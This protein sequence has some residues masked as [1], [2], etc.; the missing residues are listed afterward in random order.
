MLKQVS[1]TH[2]AHVV[3]GVDAAEDMKLRVSLIRIVDSM[4]IGDRQD[5]VCEWFSMTGRSR[6]DARKNCVES[7][8][9]FIR[10][11]PELRDPIMGALDTQTALD[12]AGSRWNRRHE[13]TQD[14]DRT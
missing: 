10:C 4:R 6:E 14:K 5:L 2:R 9:F 12:V 7:I 8:A 11:R 3:V 1:Q 13:E